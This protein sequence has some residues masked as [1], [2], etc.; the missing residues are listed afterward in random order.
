MDVVKEKKEIACQQVLTEDGSVFSLQWMVLPQR[1]AAMLTPQ[2]LLQRYLDYLRRVTLSLVRPLRTEEGLEFRL[3]STK[4][5]LLTFAVPAFSSELSIHAGTLRICEGH[6]VQAA[7]CNRGKFSFMAESVSDGVKISLQLS[8]YY[9]RLLGSRTPSFFRKWLYRL[10][11]AWVHKVMTVR[12]LAHLY[13]E[14]EGDESGFR[15]VKVFVRE[16]EEI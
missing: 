5:A 6:F 14:L 12:F 11:Q 1:H 2:F 9:P 16:G 13:Q 3:L 8:E 10:T 7:C 4:A 15:V